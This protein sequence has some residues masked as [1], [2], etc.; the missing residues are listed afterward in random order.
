MGY[1]PQKLAT[2]MPAPPR[3]RTGVPSSSTRPRDQHMN[4]G[5]VS[6][7]LKALAVRIRSV[8]PVCSAPPA[9]KMPG[10]S[11]DELLSNRQ[12]KNTQV[13]DVSTASAE[14]HKLQI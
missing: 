4:L 2:Q 5:R 8:V 14:L 9:K 7:N 11:Q 10:F 1:R 13:E 6:S 3:M 12:K